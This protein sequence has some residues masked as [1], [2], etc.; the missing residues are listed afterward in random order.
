MQLLIMTKIRIDDDA[1]PGPVLAVGAIEPESLVQGHRPSSCH[2]CCSAEH[3]GQT[4]RDDIDVGQEVDVDK[5]GNCFI[6][7]DDE[8]VLVC[9]LSN[10]V[11]VG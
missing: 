7:N 8:A 1:I 10:P 11:E 3:L 9:Q 2:V 5:V 4:S 6:T